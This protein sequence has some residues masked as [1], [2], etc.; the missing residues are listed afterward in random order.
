MTACLVNSFTGCST[1]CAGS[2]ASVQGIYAGWSLNLD[3][4]EFTLSSH[5]VQLLAH[6][7]AFLVHIIFLIKNAFLYGFWPDL[8][9]E[10]ALG[11]LVNSLWQQADLV[12]SPKPLNPLILLMMVS[13]KWQSEYGHWCV[14]AI[15]QLAEILKSDPSTVVDMLRCY[16][17]LY[18]PAKF[19]IFI[20]NHW[21][22]H[23]KFKS[24]VLS[25]CCWH[26]FIKVKDIQ[27]RCLE[28]VMDEC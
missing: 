24:C 12:D 13:L 10:L 18:H 6:Q 17:R 1:S 3:H 20:W 11:A 15:L 26:S 14:V 2:A 4:K 25:V 21:K 16:T 5:Y 19:L 23:Q 8:D 27:S 7:Q 28:S 22:E 9:T